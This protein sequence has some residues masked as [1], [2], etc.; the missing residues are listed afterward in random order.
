MT[1]L[2]GNSASATLAGINV[3][4]TAPVIS[5][6]RDKVANGAGWNNSDVTV[7]FICSDG[8]SGVAGCAS[9]K[10]FGEGIN[11]SATGLATDQAGNSASAT[12][13]GINVDETAPV[14]SASRDKVANAA[15]W[16]NSDVTVSFDCSDGLS[17]VAGCASS[18]VFGEGINQ[19]AAGLATDLAGNSASATLAGINVDETAPVISASRDKAANGAGWNNSDVTVSF[20]CSDALSGVSACATP[21]VF[22]EGAGQSAAGSATDQAGNSASTTLAGINIDETAPVISASRD[23]AANAA[24]WNNSDVAVSFSCSDALSGVGSCASLQLFGEGAGQSATGSATDLAGNSASA[25]LAGI[26][27]DE[28]A[29]LISASRDKVANAAGWNNSDVTVSFSCSDALSGVSACATPKVFGEGAG[30]S[31]A[32]S[33]TDQAGNSASATLAG[34]N[35]DETAPLISASRD[36]AA[37]GAG[38]NNSDVTVSF[39]CSDALSGVSACATPKVFGEGAGQSAAGSVIDQAGNSASATLGNINVDKT[40]P[41]ISASRDKAANGAGWNNSD[42]TV[43]FTCSDAL[44]GVGSCAS[45]QLFGEGA[46]QSATGTVTDLAGNS[47]SATMSNINV[48]KT[49]PRLT[50]GIPTPAPNAAGWNNTNVTIPYTAADALS[51]VGAPSATIVLTSEGAS[52]TGTVTVTDLAGNSATFTSPAV[53]IDKSTPTG[54]MVINGGAATTNTTAVTLTL[55]FTDNASGLAQMRF[56]SDG[57]TWTVWVAYAATS[58]FTLP[59]GDGTKTVYAQVADAAG[60]VSQVSDTIV[61]ATT[62]TPPQITITGITPGQSCDVC[63]LLT[64]RYTVTT[65]GTI[66]SQAATLDGKAI[67]NGGTIDTFYLNAGAHQIVVTATDRS[68]QTSTVKLTF[69]VHATIEGLECAVHR[70]VKLGL[71]AAQ[72]EQPLIAKLEAA[73][74]SRD[75]GNTTAEINQLQAFIQDLQAQRGKKIDPVFADRAIGWTLDLISRISGSGGGACDGDD[76]DNDDH[77]GNHQAQ[78]NEG[79]HG[80]ECCNNDGNDDDHNH[81]G[82]HQAQGNEGGHGSECCNNDGNDDDHNHN[83]N[84]QAQGAEGGHGSQGCNDDDD[85]DHHSGG[86]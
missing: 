25:T 55:N 80:S 35:V 2:A 57:T 61:L 65:S 40:A 86:K 20:I 14:I 26:N 49:A 43:S 63:V 34:I 64:F 19:S 13:A 82:N 84:H 60:N 21:K 32:G 37:N 46:G 24:G 52:V 36:K 31:A 77:D 6:S 38:W 73:K 78:G 29:P 51:G 28:T 45:S 22:G 27:V 16:N 5:A 58:P 53:K 41:L 62:A 33:V 85:D 10:V 39:T 79:G 70:A 9:S 11:Q 75:R 8:L 71:V 42:V 50:W 76:G 3:D 54:T 7:S 74:A 23:K 81:N 66:A 72:Q 17:G 44:S 83:G 30:Q 69:E 56:S 68:G 12:L 59:T 15:G 18:K 48:D 47:A 4:E 1:D 67:A